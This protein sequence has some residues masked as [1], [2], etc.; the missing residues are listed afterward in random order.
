MQ[1]GKRI[2][3][4]ID[5]G[6]TS[7]RCI[8]AAGPDQILAEEQF[9][10]TTPGDTLARAAAFFT[11]GP[12]QNAEAIGMACFGP[13]AVDPSHPRYGH[14]LSTPK[15]GW[16]DCDVLG[17]I[18]AATDRPVAIE[19]DVIAA[20][21]GEHQWGAGQDEPN[22]AY[23]TVGTGIGAGILSQGVP[24]HGALHTE[25]GHIRV[26]RHPQDIG[27]DGVC[28]FHGDC[29]EGLA[30]A[31]ALAARWGMDAA[32][33]PDDHRAWAIEAHYLA[34]LCTTLVLVAA[35]RRVILGGG[36]SARAGLVEQVARQTGD[37]LAGYEASLG[38]AGH[39]IVVRPGL[40]LKA[41]SLGA[42]AVAASALG[43]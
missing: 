42:L 6:G 10:T 17:P 34:H 31:E 29:V 1:A 25:A 11:T 13:V 37:L 19:T 28:R 23:V 35:V 8:L 39:A 21:L 18:R 9:P 16:S 3:G 26:P 40:G 4:G 30:S 27:F 14:I 15:R 22:L 41:G 24:L 32:E 43:T 5:A 20:A 2:L 38:I 33:L 12:G 36:V 7:F